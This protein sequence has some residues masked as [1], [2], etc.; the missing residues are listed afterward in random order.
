MKRYADQSSPI[1]NKCHAH[2]LRHVVNQL[3]PGDAETA[4][5]RRRCTV[6]SF[7][8]NICCCCWTVT[9]TNWH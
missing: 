5:R 7:L 9:A 8:L 4:A 2:L 1:D 3:I 6:W